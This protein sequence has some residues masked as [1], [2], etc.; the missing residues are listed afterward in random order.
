MRPSQ[1][2]IG[3]RL[4]E[5]MRSV[6]NFVKMHGIQAE[7]R[8]LFFRSEGGQH[9]TARFDPSIIAGGQRADG[10]I[11]AP[12]EPFWAKGFQEV[13]DVRL[14][15]RICPIRACLCHQ[16]GQLAVHVFKGRHCRHVFHPSVN[17]AIGDERLGA[18]VDHRS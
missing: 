6:P 13:G 7:D 8:F 1:S 18:V 10:P 4:K 5:S 17:N 2:S 3:S 15:I 14:Q 16:S 11:A 9:V 12:D